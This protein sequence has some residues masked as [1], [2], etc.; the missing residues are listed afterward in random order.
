VTG[1]RCSASLRPPRA[2][3]AQKVRPGG[4]LNLNGMPMTPKQRVLATL[5]H[6][7]PDRVPVGEYAIDYA[8]VEKVLGRPSFLR[9]KRKLIEALWDGRRDDVVD[10]IK[11]D[12]VDLTLA[13]GYDL[14]RAD[15]VWDRGRTFERPR[16]LDAETWQDAAGTMYRYSDLTHD[17]MILQEGDGP[18]PPYADPAEVRDGLRIPTESEL[19][20]VRY[21][22]ERLGTTHFVWTGPG[23]GAPGL[24]YPSALWVEPWLMSIA[25]GPDE[26]RQA[27]LAAAEGIR[28]AAAYWRE[29]GL[30]GVTGGE[31]FGHNGGPF[32]SP[33]TFRDV[34]APGLAA[35]ATAAHT[36]GMPLLFHSCGNL[37]AIWDQLAASGLDAYQAIQPEE[38]LAEL[39]RRHGHQITLWGGMSCHDLALA[40]PDAVREQTRAAL[41]TCM[42]GGGFILGSSHSLGVATRPEN[43]QAMVET[44]RE[45]GAY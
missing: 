23:T 11:R 32:M 29:Q 25:E 15:L 20:V 18:T 7:E 16:Q 10:S 44:C 37:T 9:G 24:P 6:E 40:S 14:V 30:D 38:D 21:V 31:D 42:R 3:P 39:K 45:H 43:V 27:R 12:T 2:P 36:A 22:V 35:Q 1:R 19:E 33:Q 17:L 5:R 26:V 13:L 28:K 41:Q 4:R 34:F 8:L